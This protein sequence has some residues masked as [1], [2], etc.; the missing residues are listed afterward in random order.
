MFLRKLIP[1][2]YLKAWYEDS[3]AWVKSAY[4]TIPL[5]YRMGAVFRDTTRRIERW[6]FADREKLEQAQSEL[7]RGMIE[8]AYASVPYYR[9]FMDEAGL[10]P[11]DIQDISDLPKMPLVSKEMLQ[12]RIEDFAS[13][14][15]LAE[16]VYWDNTGGSSGTPFRFLA[17]NST[18]GVEMAHILAQWKRVGYTPKHRRL[19]FRGRVLKGRNGNN[20]WRYNPIYNELQV[21]SYHLDA[22]SIAR[23]LPEVKRFRPDFLYGY[24]SALMLFLRD[25]GRQ[26]NGISLPNPGRALW[27]GTPVRLPARVPARHARLPGL[28]VVR[29]Q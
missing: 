10:R 15:K 12:R 13:T 17:L 2:S 3:P 25:D 14:A 27:I 23:L 24:P 28:L 7:L 19:T 1:F 18:Y 6:D 20:L 16:R 26:P 9:G 11:R 4:A 8:H 29:P 22:D 21:S 5:S